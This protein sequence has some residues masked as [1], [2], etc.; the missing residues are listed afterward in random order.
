SA[1]YAAL[2]VEGIQRVELKSPLK[3]IVLDQTQAGYCTEQLITFGGYD[4]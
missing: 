3:D 4:A 2:H 1:I